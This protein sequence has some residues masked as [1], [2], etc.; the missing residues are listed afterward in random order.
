[1]TPYEIAKQEVGVKETPGAGDTKRVLEYHATTTLK[2]TSDDVPWCFSGDVEL[3]TEHGWIR[4]DEVENYH[5]RVAQVDTPSMTFGLTAQWSYVSSVD[6]DVVHVKNRDFDFVCSSNHRF[7]GEFNTSK[8]G[9]QYRRFGRI[10]EATCHLRIP[11]A[12][13][14]I[15]ES[16]YTVDQ[17]MLIAAFMSDGFIQRNGVHKIAIQVS[18]ERKIST[19]DS[20]DYAGKYTAPKAYGKSKVPLTTYTFDIPEWFNDIFEG[21]K[22][23]SH[24]FIFGLGRDGAREF[25]KAYAL[26]DGYT[27]GN[28]THL[29]SSVPYIRD[30][31]LTIAV[32]A[33]YTPVVNS[34]MSSIS[35]K[36]CWNVR[37]AG[38]KTSKMIKAINIQKA[39]PCGR[40]H[41]V[42]VPTGAIVVRDRNM[43]PFVT[44]NCSSF[45]NWCVEQAGLRGT[46][47]AAARS[48]LDWGTAVDLPQEGDIVILR[49]G[50]PPSGHV[51]FFVKSAGDIIYVLGG[52]QSDQ[53][54]VS[55][56]KRGDL[57][58]YRRP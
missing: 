14:E 7:F 17:I 3:L 49:R 4:L 1:M 54:K 18:K 19:L 33:G 2:A 10:D 56:Y 53:V 35:G 15:A 45:V 13:F 21:Y 22:Q 48:W 27:R 16:D 43:T 51:G 12:A 32:M 34:T 42:T 31:I 9:P 30:A 52:N 20:M 40:L 6:P 44:G 11:S 36:P 28:C 26:F 50:N 57:L 5:G 39:Q 24:R 47:S 46:R 38:G 25:L 58:G 41:C 29:Y 8:R 55:G 23:P 37:W